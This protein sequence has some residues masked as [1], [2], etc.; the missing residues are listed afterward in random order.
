VSGDPRCQEIAAG[1]S[2]LTSKPGRPCAPT[3][4]RLVLAGISTTGRHLP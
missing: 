2:W 1:F 4:P 3:P